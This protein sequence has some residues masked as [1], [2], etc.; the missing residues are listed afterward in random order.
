[1]SIIP[2][3]TETTGLHYGFKTKSITDPSHPH[4]VQLSALVVD[5]E[6][7]RITQSMNLIV[8]P[9]GWEIPPEAS[10]VHGITTEYAEKHGLPEKEVL[11]IFLALWAGGEAYPL[12]RVAHNALF[13]KNVI[14]TAIARHFGEG[15]LLDTWLSGRDFCTMQTAK[16]IVQA[17][18]K[19][20]ALKFPNL[21]EAH[22]HFFGETFDRQHTANADV[23]ATYNIY[24]ALQEGM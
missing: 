24:R 8:C 22:E 16:P 23:V 4:L 11:S 9:D 5:T 2:Y 6:V 13:D 17:R 19:R 12:E 7:N 21:M 15:E 10:A 1:M 3:D 20:G 18:N 14:A